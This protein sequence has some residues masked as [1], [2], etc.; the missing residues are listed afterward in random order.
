MAFRP[1]T[2]ADT[3]HGRETDNRTVNRS[4]APPADGCGA[5]ASGIA[6]GDA[7]AASPLGV[8]RFAALRSCAAAGVRTT[9]VGCGAFTA[10]AG[11]TVKNAAAC[12]ASVRHAPKYTA[13][14]VTTTPASITRITA[15][16]RR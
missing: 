13:H 14:P 3:Q 16:T 10:G 11:R 15:D 9:G 8:A 6:S 12:D 4:S 5:A 2:I 1:S 7:A